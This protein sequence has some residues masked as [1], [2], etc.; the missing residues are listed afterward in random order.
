MTTNATKTALFASPN[1]VVFSYPVSQISSVWNSLSFAVSGNQGNPVAIWVGSSSAPASDCNLNTLSVGAISNPTAQVVVPFCTLGQESVG[2]WYATLF[3]TAPSTEADSCQYPQPYAITP[4]FDG[5]ETSS[6]LSDNIPVNGNLLITEVQDNYIFN[7]GDISNTSLVYI[8]YSATGNGAVSG[9]L[10]YFPSPPGSDNCGT[11]IQP[12]ALQTLTFVDEPTTFFV[13]ISPENVI[14]PTV[15]VTYL[16]AASVISPTLLYAGTENF[17]TSLLTQPQP[18]TDASL[19]IYQVVITSQESLV[20]QLTINSGP[21][22]GVRLYPYSS[23]LEANTGGI[24]FYC[25]AGSC[26]YPFGMVDDF[27]GFETYL[28]VVYGA[29]SNYTIGYTAGSDNCAEPS[30]DLLQFCEIDYPTWQY[31]SFAAKDAYAQQLYN[32]LVNN[33]QSPQGQCFQTTLTR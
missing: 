2:T 15:P 29:A 23:A 12:G 11:D 24:D 13:S 14:A 33:L 19:D 31:G 22:V 9:V 10:N 28:I 27:P 18:I 1:V 25:F 5:T 6:T 17:Q 20:L 7:T 21:A 3:S 32:S 4:I 16:I 26:F 8:T 30:S